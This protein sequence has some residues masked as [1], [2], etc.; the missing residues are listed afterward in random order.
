MLLDFFK[1]I[2]IGFN[3]LKVISLIVVFAQTPC[4]KEKVTW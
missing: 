2:E 4:L 3:L 1:Q